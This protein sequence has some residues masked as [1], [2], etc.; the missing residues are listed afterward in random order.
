MYVDHAGQRVG[1][2]LGIFKHRNQ[3]VAVVTELDIDLIDWVVIKL[4]IDTGV[5]AVTD[6]EHAD[7]G[8]VFPSKRWTVTFPSHAQL[9]LR[10]LREYLTSSPPPLLQQLIE[11]HSCDGRD[12]YQTHM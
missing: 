1:Y 6:M 7:N 8:I 3:I 9:I 4:R 12:E 11:D 10:E 5:V 2:W